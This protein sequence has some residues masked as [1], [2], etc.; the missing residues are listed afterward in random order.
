M[1][2]WSFAAY[3]RHVKQS[4]K[5]RRA[6]RLL[7]PGDFVF[8]MIGARWGAPWSDTNE[9]TRARSAASRA[10]EGDGGDA[11]LVQGA[12]TARGVRHRLRLPDRGLRGTRRRRHAARR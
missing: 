12:R 4:A 6:R 2:P 3:C 7:R 8:L 1:V 10:E 9:P 5:T 11:R